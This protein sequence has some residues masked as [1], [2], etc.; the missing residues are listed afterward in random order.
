MWS[1]YIQLWDLKQ[2]EIR[3]IN[4]TT[5]HSN[6]FAVTKSSLCPGDIHQTENTI[7]TLR[8]YIIDYCNVLIHSKVRLTLT[9]NA[10]LSEPIIKQ[11]RM[12]N[13]NN[14]SVNLIRKFDFMQILVYS[15]QICAW[16]IFRNKLLRCWCERSDW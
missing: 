1:K 2:T 10:N 6:K 12:R 3:P 5:N 15:N 9:T 8:V 16:K 4:S 7:L 14:I 13:L 11:S